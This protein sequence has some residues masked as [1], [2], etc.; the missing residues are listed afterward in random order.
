MKR[1]QECSNIVKLWRYRWY[2]LIP[3]KWLYYTVVGFMIQDDSTGEYFISR[4]KQLWKLL[5]GVAQI[6]MEW[7]YTSEEVFSKL[8]KSEN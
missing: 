5:I 7:H 8:D 3:F 2:L 1:F 6:K 4:G